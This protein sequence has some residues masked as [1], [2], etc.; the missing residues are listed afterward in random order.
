MNVQ[1]IIWLPNVEDKLLEKHNVLVAEVEEMLFGNPH[2]RFAERGHREGEN[3]YA[4]YG[5]TEAGRWL[6]VFFILKDCD[7]ALVISARD[8]ARKERRLYARR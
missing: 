6:I 7:T 4:A 3:L 8:M 1:R 2:V 5:Q